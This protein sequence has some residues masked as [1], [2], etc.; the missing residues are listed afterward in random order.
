MFYSYSIV[1]HVTGYQILLRYSICN[2]AEHT[3]MGSLRHNFYPDYS[4]H[5]EHA[6]TLLAEDTARELTR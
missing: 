5:K 3:V 6:C 2:Q 1:T 4:T